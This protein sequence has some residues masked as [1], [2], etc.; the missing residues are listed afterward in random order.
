[1]AYIYNIVKKEAGFWIARPQ[2]LG[3]HSDLF[4]GKMYMLLI[5]TYDILARLFLLFS[6]TF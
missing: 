6:S 5:W 3:I 4:K 1:M 2:D